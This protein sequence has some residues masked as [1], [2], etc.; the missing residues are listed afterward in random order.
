MKRYCI[1]GT[2][3]SEKRTGIHRF[4]EEI[5]KALDSLITL[6]QDFVL[7][8]PKHTKIP[9]VLKNIPIIEYGFLKGIPWEQTFFAL[10]ALLHRRIPLNLCNVT[11]ILVPNGYSV[12]HDISYKVNPQYFSHWY[13]LLSRKWHCLNYWVITHFAKHIFTVS[14]FS[15]NEIKNT[16]KVS[17]QRITVIYN[18]WQH[19]QSITPSNDYILNQLGLTKKNFF[20]SLSTIAPNKNLKWVLKAAQNNPDETFVIAGSLNPSR[21]GTDLDITNLKNVKFIGYISDEDFV[22][23]AKNCKAFLFPSFYEGFGIPPLEA[24]SVGAP[25]IVSNIPVLKEIF[26]ESAHY[27]DPQNYY[28]SLKDTTELLTKNKSDILSKYNWNDSAKSVLRCLKF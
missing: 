1:N 4:A 2:F 3:L 19:M 16:Y 21:F 7:V 27:I 26:E 22:L 24:M 15:Q 23:L 28:V 8:V 17:S 18:G 10:F 13:G 20:L 12:I 14:H 9:F 5:I 11:P 25:V 6:N